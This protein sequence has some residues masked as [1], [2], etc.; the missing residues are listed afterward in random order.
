MNDLITSTIVAAANV[1]F[2]KRMLKLPEI[3]AHSVY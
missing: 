1:V 3:I 2:I